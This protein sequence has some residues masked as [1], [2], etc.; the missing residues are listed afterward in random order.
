MDVTTDKRTYL[1]F[2]AAALL[3]KN[4]RTY[5]DYMSCGTAGCWAGSSLL[6][7]LREHL[8]LDLDFK[9]S[10]VYFVKLCKCNTC[11]DCLEGQVKNIIHKKSFKISEKK[12]IKIT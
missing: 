1:K 12:Q 9:I 11:V 5:Q 10:I 4:D 2:N 3:I 8:V 6:T 7:D